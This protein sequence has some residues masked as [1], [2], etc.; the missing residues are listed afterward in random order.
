HVRARVGVRDGEHVDPVERL[1]RGREGAH[2]RP[3]PRDDDRG[4]DH[5]GSGAHV[6][7]APRARGRPAVRSTGRT[8]GRAVGTTVATRARC[9]GR[10]AHAEARAEATEGGPARAGLRSGRRIGYPDEV[11]RVLRAPSTPSRSRRRTPGET[12]YRP[13]RTSPL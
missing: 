12:P 2:R 4:V 5:V 9:R 1:A 6:G 13:F 3:A 11:A 10:A 7:P 8:T